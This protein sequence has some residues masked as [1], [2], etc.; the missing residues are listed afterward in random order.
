VDLAAGSPLI[1]RSLFGPNP[2]F[3][4]RFYGI[5]NELEATLPVLMLAGVAAALGP[6][7]RSRGAALAYAAA[8]TFFALALGAGRL[9]ADVGGVI[10]VG[11]ATAVAVALVA[12]GRVTRRRLAAVVLAPVAAVAAL[13]AIDLATGGDSHFTRT[14]LHAGDRAAL[15]DAILR[16]YELALNVLEKP[17]MLVLTPLSLAA[18][19]IAIL[20]RDAIL[21]GIPGAERWGAALAGAAAAGVAGALFNDSGPLLL[22]FSTFMAAWILAYL[23]AGVGSRN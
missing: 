14:V 13:A 3:G 6:G 18:I 10:T 15:G 23:R 22:V 9:G 11:A 20:R 17:A 5:G 1:V 21:Q 2:L 7:G 16:R 19:A 8:G 4:A 12:P